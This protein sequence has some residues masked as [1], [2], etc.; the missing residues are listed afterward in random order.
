MLAEIDKLR[1][2][3]VEKCKDTLLDKLN[4]PNSIAYSKYSSF[5]TEAFYN[6]D[7]RIGWKYFY[8]EHKA[9]L[10]PIAKQQGQNKQVEEYWEDLIKSAIA[11]N[12]ENAL[13]IQ[14]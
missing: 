11:L 14:N 3:V 5:V 7:A 2:E 8:D 4:Y 10:Y 6:D 9:I 13:L 12:E 1:K